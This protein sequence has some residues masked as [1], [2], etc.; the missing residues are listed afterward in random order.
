MVA[1][2]LGSEEYNHITSHWIQVSLYRM[3]CWS[4]PLKTILLPSCFRR[5]TVLCN[6]ALFHR[7]F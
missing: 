7:T 1:S 4:Y 3:I 2:L 6:D 5:K